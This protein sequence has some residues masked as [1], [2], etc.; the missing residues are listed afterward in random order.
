MN[1]LN[2]I[3]TLRKFGNFLVGL[4]PFLAVVGARLSKLTGTVWLEKVIAWLKAHKRLAPVGNAI[5]RFFW[6]DYARDRLVADTFPAGTLTL[7]RVSSLVTLALTLC[8]PLAFV[9]TKPAVPVELNSGTISSA[10]L[11]VVYLWIIGASLGWGAIL[12]GAAQCHR[13]IFAVLA[14][15][16]VWFV[17]SC[18]LFSPRSYFNWLLPATIYLAIHYS[19][20]K[21]VRAE[22]ARNFP[23]VLS[24][25]VAGS[26][27]GMFLIV[28]C[29]LGAIAKPY[30]LQWGAAVGC[31]LGLIALLTANQKDERAAVVASEEVAAPVVTITF[32]LV[33]LIL[34]FSFSVVIRGGVSPFA[35]Q[36]IASLQQWNGFLWPL[37]YFVGVGIVYKLLKNAKIMTYTVRDLLSA[38]IFNPL[39]VLIIVGAALVVC[40]GELRGELSKVDALLPVAVFFNNVYHASGWFWSQ[41]LNQLAAPWMSY[42]LLFDLIAILWMAIRKQ[43]N[44]ERLVTMLYFTTLCWLLIYEYQ[45]Q[46]SSF[47][48]SPG[49]N[50]MVVVTFAVW[51]LWLFHTSVFAMCSQSTR[52]WPKGGRVGLYCGLISLCLLMIAARTVVKDFK[53]TNEIFLVMFRGIIDIGLPYFLYVLSVRRFE[54]L[55]IRVLRV[56]QCFCAG[57]LAT[58]P[59]NVLDKLALSDWSLYRF[60]DLLKH[61]VANLSTHGYLEGFTVILPETWVLIRSLLY[62]ALLAALLLVGRKRLVKDEAQFPA[63]IIFALLSF[64]SGFGSF[65]KT[66]VDLPLPPLLTALFMPFNVSYA[67]DW[68]WIFSYLAVLLPCLFFA[69]LTTAGKALSSV[70]LVGVGLM[71]AVITFC[72]W[73]AYPRYESYLQS[74]DLMNTLLAA[75][76]MLFLYMIFHIVWKLESTAD[77][78][79]KRKPETTES[80]LLEEEDSMDSELQFVTMGEDEEETPVSDADGNAAPEPKPLIDVRGLTALTAAACI[81]LI[82]FGCY[83]ANAKRLVPQSVPPLNATMMLPADWRPGKA[84]GGPSAIFISPGQNLNSTLEIGTLPSNPEGVEALAIALAKTCESKQVLPKFATQNILRWREMP[85]KPAAIY[86]RFTIK[87]GEI[88]MPRFGVTALVPRDDGK[89]EYLTICC[90]ADESDE[91][92]GDLKRILQAQASSSN[93][94]LGK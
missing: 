3:A 6:K 15:A 73:T 58:F 54:R 37:W 93:R 66:N 14:V 35:G 38:R 34:A 82:A 7:L 13:V 80:M 5:E 19:G 36:I 41:Q 55:P 68:N 63:A 23:A 49:H 27:A 85:G 26:A 24:A 60:F 43:L 57:A 46:F 65:C 78:L 67:I 81:C 33:P 42:I 84:A 28:L 92:I 22:G 64:A 8:T 88:E 2:V 76:G 69:L 91:R 89:T 29:P 61:E 94:L 17:G 70:R 51:L 39:A 40:S 4:F 75:C 87:V 56:F 83:R 86:F 12:A 45:F 71:T 47:A 11:W 79:R 25:L 31:V 18:A 59:F 62:T 32:T 50:V 21:S 9:L 20:Y 72:L 1:P 16:C 48:Q 52:S 10:P 44:E 74:T 30:G 90:F 77:I 53:V